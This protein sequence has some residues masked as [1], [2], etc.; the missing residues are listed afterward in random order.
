M[1]VNPVNILKI[2]DSAHDFGKTRGTGENA[3]SPPVTELVDIINKTPA[4]DAEPTLSA[5]LKMLTND[6]VSSVGTAALGDLAQPQNPLD[7]NSKGVLGMPSIKDRKVSYE[8]RSNV[9]AEKAL[10]L[11][12]HFEIAMCETNIVTYEQIITGKAVGNMFTEDILV[13]TNGDNQA[14]KW[15]T[16]L[17][18][19]KTGNVPP[20]GQTGDP[21]TRQ[22]ARN[23]LGHFILQY[24]FPGY[25]SDP[26]GVTYDAAGDKLT[27]AFSGIGQVH[28]LITPQ[29]ISDSA[30]SQL[31]PFQ[32]SFKRFGH[33]RYD[34]LF[35]MASN[36]IVYDSLL[37]SND[38][39]RLVLVNDSFGPNN[40][41]GFKLVIKSPDGASA[42]AEIPYNTWTKGVP[43]GPGAG[44]LTG[45]IRA[46]RTATTA[47]AVARAVAAAPPLIT[48]ILELSGTLGHLKNNAPG[49]DIPNIQ[50]F[51]FDLKRTGDY[52]QVNAAKYQAER[53]AEKVILGTGDVLCSTYARSQKVPC[54][55]QGV[56]GAGTDTMVLFRF[57]QGKPSAE[58]KRRRQYFTISQQATT[59]I[60]VYDEWNI[61]VEGE[62]K[63][64]QIQDKLLKWSQNG[65][66]IG[67]YENKIMGKGT[68]GFI[69]ETAKKKIATSINK[70]LTC[71]LRLK[72]KKMATDFGQHCAA[73]AA[74]HKKIGEAFGGVINYGGDPWSGTGSTLNLKDL[75]ALALDSETWFN[76]HPTSSGSKTLE[77]FQLVVDEI[78]THIAK[79]TEF[80]QK[81]MGEDIKKK[82]KGDLMVLVNKI[83]ENKEGNFV[84]NDSA[85]NPFYSHLNYNVAQIVILGKELFDFFRGIAAKARQMF[86]RPK[87]G[88]WETL[89][90]KLAPTEP[91]PAAFS[92]LTKYYGENGYGH[93]IA[94]TDAGGKNVTADIVKVIVDGIQ[95]AWQREVDPRL[96]VV[97][98]A[99][100][101]AAAAA[102]A[103][104]QIAATSADD[105]R[106]KETKQIANFIFQQMPEFANKLL[107]AEERVAGSTVAS[108][109][110]GLLPGFV[111][112]NITLAGGGR[113]SGGTPPGHS[114]GDRFYHK[115]IPAVQK[116]LRGK[117]AASRKTK[118]QLL[119]RMNRAAADGVNIWKPAEL[120]D[121]GVDFYNYLFE[122]LEDIS[123]L[124]SE[125]L[126]QNISDIYNQSG[127]ATHWPLRYN[128]YYQLYIATN[129]YYNG[130]SEVLQKTA[131]GL[132]ENTLEAP[133]IS[134]L[135][136][137]FK[138]I[139]LMAGYSNSMVVDPSDKQFID[140]VVGID[141]THM[142]YVQEAQA[143]AKAAVDAAQ[144]QAMAHMQAAQAQAMAHVQTAQAWAVAH[145]QAAQAQAMAHVQDAVQAQAKAVAA[146]A[147]AA[148][149]ASMALNFRKKAADAAGQ[150]IP[151]LN[152]MVTNPN[153]P[154]VKNADVI[155]EKMRTIW[156]NG[157]TL[158]LQD[159]YPDGLFISPDVGKNI[160]I[161]GR[162]TK[163]SRCGGYVQN[164]ISCIL[165]AESAL[166]PVQKV[167]GFAKLYNILN[168]NYFPFNIVSFCHSLRT[169][170]LPVPSGR[171]VV[172]VGG[173]VDINW[174]QVHLPRVMLESA[175]AAG[176]DGPRDA[177]WWGATAEV[178][179][180]GSQ[181]VGKIEIEF[182]KDPMANVER[183]KEAML[184][185]NLGPYMFPAAACGGGEGGQEACSLPPRW[186]AA[187][188]LVKN[189]TPQVTPTPAPAP[190][191]FDFP[192]PPPEDATMV[193][194]GVGGDEGEG[195]AGTAAM[196]D[197]GGN[198]QL[199]TR[200]RK[201]RRR[202]TKRRVRRKH[203]RKRRQRKKKQ[204]RRKQRKN[205]KK[206]KYRHKRRYKRGTTR[207]RYR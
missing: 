168:Y 70:F 144:A 88:D 196:V 176:V 31:H 141:N 98:P 124:A 78:Q 147:A 169:G 115:T 106:E 192:P 61:I 197:G 199:H 178:S 156:R 77:K 114:V 37:Y 202:N 187:P 50:G 27:T 145:V 18:K 92:L 64:Q 52:E 136:S 10:G 170:W 153:S 24:M 71:I 97:S 51:L 49:I 12:G 117:T 163:M 48:N 66:Y 112:L 22:Q 113:L 198:L 159:S 135:V 89:R 72:C 87:A 184:G 207:K 62:S 29:N 54:I 30:S 203:S 111:K 5:Q 182:Q 25:K 130:Y 75:R 67:A 16:M 155:V 152:W 183:W 134:G 189:I 58:D 86:A 107:G 128:I 90:G 201:R 186:A 140:S 200:K 206:R 34:V 57:P 23:R 185:L 36:E 150:F 165:G 174:W 177:A 41:T 138:N 126:D 73:I 55:L 93:L 180:A 101:V 127:G 205:R 173:S 7:P 179:M 123:M 35:P 3:L 6:A 44:Y 204:T 47:D 151:L 116:R 172:V 139:Q 96:L 193:G 118:R 69:D 28:A 40:M 161:F 149:I 125:Y 148:P 94:W 83:G 13:L 17:N 191:P 79:V 14:Y 166:T 74:A 110:Q 171:A 160:P 99:Y 181:R 137:E 158:A 119:H 80:T 11:K 133:R 195:E 32:K 121:G 143:Q 20:D 157:Y 46:I 102:A 15:E 76:V 188:E 109:F 146:A 81:G 142:A 19:K 122:T 164:L 59:I 132:L 63:I 9:W 104:G 53:S 154:L 100:K 26:V 65:I 95:S 21:L 33:K 162:Q 39:L 129:H 2:L 68:G 43:Q 4:V 82:S 42:Y 131:A 45:L 105:A 194:V 84:F 190:L 120:G 8:R 60:G 167:I 85:R 56:G 103:A 91:L 175:P 38:K 1:A 108:I